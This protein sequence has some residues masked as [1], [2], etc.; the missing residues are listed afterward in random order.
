MIPHLWERT[1][2][3]SGWEWVKQVKTFL[4]HSCLKTFS[5]NLCGLERKHFWKLLQNKLYIWKEFEWV[6]GKVLMYI[7]PSKI[8]KCSCKREFTKM[9]KRFR[10]LQAMTVLNC[11]LLSDSS[12]INI[13]RSSPDSLS[14]LSR[15]VRTVS[16]IPTVLLKPSRIGKGRA[17]LGERFL[18]RNWKEECGNADK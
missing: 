18:K 16:L 11:N 1:S 6:V 14:L 12:G 3:C 5:T 10:L 17:V 7:S 4:T 2:I 15:E 8:Q 9:I 13:L